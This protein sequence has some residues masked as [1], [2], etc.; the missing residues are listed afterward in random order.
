MGLALKG[1]SGF[2]PKLGGRITGKIC[3]FSVPGVDGIDSGNSDIIRAVV[4]PASSQVNDRSG[5]RFGYQ[6]NAATQGKGLIGRHT[7]AIHDHSTVVIDVESS[8]V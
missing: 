3:S 6:S 2:T 7:A 4:I 8:P 1:A 5:D